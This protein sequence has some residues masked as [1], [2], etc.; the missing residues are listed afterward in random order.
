[1]GTSVEIRGDGLRG[2]LWRPL[3]GFSRGYLLAL[4]VTFIVGA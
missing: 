2:T 3:N 4:A 1:M